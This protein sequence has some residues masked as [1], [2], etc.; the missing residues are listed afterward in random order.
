M[1][2][3][4]NNLRAVSASKYPP[5]KEPEMSEP[6]ER[7]DD[8]AGMPRSPR[9]TNAEVVAELMEWSRNGVFMQLFILTAIEKYAKQVG[10]APQGFMGDGL[11][12]EELWRRCANEAAAAIDAHLSQ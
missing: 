12:N 3:R 2:P 7:T 8:G 10:A 9:K 4:K 5:Y 1:P 11:I 6:E